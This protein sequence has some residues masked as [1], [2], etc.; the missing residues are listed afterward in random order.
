MGVHVL[1]IICERLGIFLVSSFDIFEAMVFLDNDCY[2][3]E[4]VSILRVVKVNAK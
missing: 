2:F 4:I 3:I 1:G